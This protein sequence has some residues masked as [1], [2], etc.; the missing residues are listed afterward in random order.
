[1]EQNSIKVA[2]QQAANKTLKRGP[3]TEKSTGLTQDDLDKRKYIELKNK[4]NRKSIATKNRGLEER[5]NEVE[6]LLK[7]K[8][9]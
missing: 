5:Y 4:I 3:P 9:E 7:S 8:I 6:N 1:M 2:V